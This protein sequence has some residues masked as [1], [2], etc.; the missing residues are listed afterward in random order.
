MNTRKLQN[1]LTTYN[2]HRG[3]VTMSHVS[4]LV[5]DIPGLTGKQLGMVMSA[6]NRAYHEGKASCG[7]EVDGDWVYINKLEK[8]YE[9][10]DIKRINEREVRHELTNIPMDSGDRWSGCHGKWVD[11]KYYN[12]HSVRHNDGTKI[13][14]HVLNYKDGDLIA[15]GYCIEKIAEFN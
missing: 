13:T 2:G 11:G 6:V 9:L 4:S 3:P 15:N 8:G 14:G 7:A 5:G 12:L 10:K 1:M